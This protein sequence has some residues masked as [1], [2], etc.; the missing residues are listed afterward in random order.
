MMLAGIIIIFLFL[1]LLAFVLLSGHAPVKTRTREHF[2]R[3][4]GE[5]VEAKVEPIPGK[6]DSFHCDF[7]FEGQPF[8][9]EDIKES[10]FGNTLPR[11]KVYLK[12]KTTSR[13]NLTFSEREHKAMKGNI[14]MASQIP[15]RE[16]TEYVNV[17]VPSALKEFKIHT[18]LPAKANEFLGDDQVVAILS[19][20]KNVNERG[21]SSLAT[22]IL[23]GLINLESY[24]S[25]ALRPSLMKIYANTSSLEQYF[26]KLIVLKQKLER[27]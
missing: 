19:E 6:P 12:L 17:H 15:E 24:P 18:N 25:A 14:I 5:F 1:G 9:F 4:V 2:L 8:S 11:N 3:E 7:Q 16:A 13:L 23:D 26:H 22:R 20:F 27:T 21:F 10:G